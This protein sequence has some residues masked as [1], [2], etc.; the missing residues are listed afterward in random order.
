MMHR[1]IQSTA[2]LAMAFL[3]M[4]CGGKEQKKIEIIRPVMYQKVVPGRKSI[5]RI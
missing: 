4:A 5:Y 1:K 3:M 2:Y